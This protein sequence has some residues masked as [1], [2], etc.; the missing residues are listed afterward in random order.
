MIRRVLTTLIVLVVL[1]AVVFFFAA[2]IYIA[3]EG[4]TIVADRLSRA[5]AR[6]VEVKDVRYEFPFSVAVEGLRIPGA[7]EVPRGLLTLGFPRLSSRQ[8]VFSEILL[9]APRFA[10]ERPAGS[11]LSWRWL[12]G[13][14]GRESSKKDRATA[15]DR[16]E[17]APAERS[18]FSTMTNAGEGGIYAEEVRIK[19]ALIDFIDYSYESPQKVRLEN[20]SLSLRNIF[21]PLRPGRTGLKVSG[22]IKEAKA[23]LK[24]SRFNMNGWIDPA[25]KDLDLDLNIAD[26]KGATLLEADLASKANDMLIKGRMTAGGLS[27]KK[28]EGPL[29]G[30]VWQALKGADI[31]MDLNFSFR[32]KMDDFRIERISVQGEFNLEGLGNLSLP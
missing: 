30:G 9:T 24:G 18:V 23:F 32:T 20:V 13:I 19:N 15:E 29:P 11:P 14:G 6:D 22:R 7:L 3:A 26:D 4:K 25:Q 21:F 1:L 16:D 2:Q 28:E 10:L 5:F 31:G 8:I 17:S 27:P 12:A